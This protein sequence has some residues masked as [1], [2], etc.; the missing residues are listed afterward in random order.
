[1][2]Q[3]QS[4]PARKTANEPCSGLAQRTARH[5]RSGLG[6]ELAQISDVMR[7][8]VHLGALVDLVVHLERQH[9]AGWGR[10]DRCYDAIEPLTDAAVAVEDA[11]NFFTLEECAL[12]AE[13]DEPSQPQNQIA[14]A[15]KWPKAAG[16]NRLYSY[17][18][19]N[20]IDG[21]RY[22]SPSGS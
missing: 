17:I 22:Q 11:L 8:A 5:G 13:P 9:T 15:E 21:S 20:Y 7:Q 18:G 19:H 2:C 6:A 10:L 4:S 1:M 16:T 3:Y 14:Q 12:R